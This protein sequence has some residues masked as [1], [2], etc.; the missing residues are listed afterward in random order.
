M[1]TYK[2]SSALA[3]LEELDAA[4]AGF[5]DTLDHARTH[6]DYV[7][8]ELLL[9]ADLDNL[10]RYREN[11][12]EHALASGEVVPVES[13]TESCDFCVNQENRHYCLLHSRQLK[14]MDTVRCRDW[15]LKGETA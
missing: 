6:D 9:G 5:D 13:R 8:L 14:N 4:I 3:L 11:V 2:S 7:G 10:K 15:E 12:F 1:R